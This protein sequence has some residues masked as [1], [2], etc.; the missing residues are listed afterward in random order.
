MDSLFVVVFCFGDY[1]IEIENI[2]IG[3]I[4]MDMMMVW[5]SLVVFIVLVLDMVYIFCEIG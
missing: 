3:C 5:V 4:N 1:I 2:I